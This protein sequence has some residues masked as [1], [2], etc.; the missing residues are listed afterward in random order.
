MWH[1]HYPAN[2][3]PHLEGAAHS[4]AQRQVHLV[5]GRHHNSRDVLAR[6]ARNGQHYDGQE[7]GADAGVLA[8][9]L[10]RACQE[11]GGVWGSQHT[12]HGARRIQNKRKKDARL[13][14]SWGCVGITQAHW[15]TARM[16]LMRNTG[17][18][19]GAKAALMIQPAPQVLSP[20]CETHGRVRASARVYW[21]AVRDDLTASAVSPFIDWEAW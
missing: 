10:E 7:G 21:R 6:I 4:D 5:L 17:E 9:L 8:R 18:A 16:L 2:V 20:L 14:G 1:P 19:T 11:P 15:H 13:P 3:Q 12:A